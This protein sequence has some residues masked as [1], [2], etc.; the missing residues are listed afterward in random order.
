LFG[1][2]LS[3][4]TRK[5]SRNGDFF[6]TILHFEGALKTIKKWGQ[7]VTDVV[8]VKIKNIT[9]LNLTHLNVGS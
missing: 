1:E 7:P 6:Q 2:S 8:M 4:I 5:S 9:G 3:W